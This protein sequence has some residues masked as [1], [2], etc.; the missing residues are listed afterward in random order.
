L[1]GSRLDGLD[2][3]I[4]AANHRVRGH[5]CGRDLVAMVYLAVG[6]LNAGPVIA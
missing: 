3:R 4:R 6:R 5:R 2:S 1:S